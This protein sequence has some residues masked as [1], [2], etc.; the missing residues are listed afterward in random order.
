MRFG[1][2]RAARVIEEQAI[3][4]GGPNGVGLQQPR[5]SG[6]KEEAAGPAASSDER[7]MQRRLLRIQV[8]LA[9]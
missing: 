3:L 8:I 9:A 7:F 1:E 5:S 4:L 6:L 2:A